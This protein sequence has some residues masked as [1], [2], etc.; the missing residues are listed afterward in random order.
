VIKN[1]TY[2]LFACAV[3]T[4]CKAPEDAAGTIPAESQQDRPPDTRFSDRFFEGQTALALGQPDKAYTAFEACL[5]LDPKNSAVHYELARLDTASSNL[6]A[7]TQHLRAAL[8]GDED[9]PWYHRMMGE[10]YEAQGKWELAAKE[11]AAVRKLNPLD[12]EVIFAQ[13]DALLRAG[14]LQE[15]IAV[16]DELEKSDGIAPEISLQKHQLYLRLNN[17]EKAGMELEKL[18]RAFPQDPQ[19]WGMCAQFYQQIGRT[20]KAVYALEQL[21]LNNPEDGQVHMQLSEYYAA[22]GDE[23]RSLEEL[24]LAF[25]APDVSIDQKIGMLLRYFSLT[26]FDPSQLPVAYE[27]LNSTVETHPGEAKA[28]SMYGDFLYRDNKLAEARE[29]YRKA[30]ALDPAKN[31]IWQQVLIID[32]E[33]RDYA[34][35]ETESARAM[36]LFSLLPEFYY[37]N[38]LAHIKLGSYSKAVASLRT[39]KDLVI[40]DDT[41]LIQFLLALGEAYHRSQQYPLCDQ[42]MA[43][44]LNVNPD[45]PRVLNNYAYFLS[46]RGE[47]LDKALQMV[48]R[49]MELMPGSA[50]FTDTYAWILYRQ[51]QF[52]RALAEIEKAMA[53]M[54]PPDAELT[55]HYG[56]ILFRNGREEQAVEQWKA[57]RA[58][59]SVSPDLDKKIAT[60]RLEN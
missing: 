50:P 30:V 55:E 13:A 5:G 11:Y 48:M 14:K 42:A 22:S 28:F 29:K 17:A 49:A 21:R 46:L 39:G 51:G 44:A 1:L 26:D 34:A 45:N 32:N 43:E 54:N 6:T 41:M 59:G 37:Y 38:G 25:R 16:I 18:A 52:A 56:D 20:D 3:L 12:P 24:K 58:L 19:Y 35:M 47:N 57:A 36:T 2:I 8:A 27:L 15:S 33:L 10:L 60:R 31:I 23:A 9:N 53:M 40:L 4:A 7:A